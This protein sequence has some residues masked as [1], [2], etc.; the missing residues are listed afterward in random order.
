MPTDDFIMPWGKYE[1]QEMGELP[2]GYLVWLMENCSDDAIRDI[3][4]EEWEWRRD[5]NLTR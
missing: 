5:S 4:Q 2:A 3:A 1:G